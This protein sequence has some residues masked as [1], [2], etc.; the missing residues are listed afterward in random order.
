VS[1][2]ALPAT[3]WEAGIDNPLDIRTTEPLRPWLNRERWAP[4]VVGCGQNG[5]VSWSWH[6]IMLTVCQSGVLLL[7]Y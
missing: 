2:G 4:R 1:L 7:P 5:L 3:L 6:H